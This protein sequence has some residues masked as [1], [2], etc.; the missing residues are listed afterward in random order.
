MPIPAEMRWLFWD[1]DPGEVDLD[2]DA[3]WILARVLERGRL[4]DVKWA[5]G[6]YGL[7]RIRR[8]FEEAGHPGV[9]RRTISFWKSVFQTEGET[10]RTPS[11]FRMN[12]SIPWP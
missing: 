4:P 9:S 6:A 1:V 5:M 8:F 12:S 2:R 3:D 11:P 10:W 7:R